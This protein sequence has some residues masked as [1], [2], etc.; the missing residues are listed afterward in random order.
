M[1]EELKVLSTC[2]GLASLWSTDYATE[3]TS[4]IMNQERPK[5]VKN[6]V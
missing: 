4:L 6:K 2:H 1:N 3:R 5:M